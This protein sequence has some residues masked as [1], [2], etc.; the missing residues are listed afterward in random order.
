MNFYAFVLVVLLPIFA[1]SA[2]AFKVSSAPDSGPRQPS[3]VQQKEKSAQ[4]VTTNSDERQYA[5]LAAWRKTVKEGMEVGYPQFGGYHIH[6]YPNGLQ[7]MTAQELVVQRRGELVQLSNNAWLK[8]SSIWPICEGSSYIP[9]DQYNAIRR[10]NPEQRSI[11]EWRSTIKRGAIVI[12]PALPK[13]RNVK[14]MP[15]KNGLQ[16][17]DIDPGDSLIVV[18]VNQFYIDLARVDDWNMGMRDQNLS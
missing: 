12:V 2:W 11:H 18:D 13:Y 8:I 14:L 6:V 7:C 10:L 9:L 17:A 5:I 15:S 4:S 3:G 16:C 1:N